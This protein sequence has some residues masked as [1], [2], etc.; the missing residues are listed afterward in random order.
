MTENPNRHPK[1]T[2]VGGQFAA[3]AHAE[4]DLTLPTGEPPVSLD[5]ALGDTTMLV[6]EEHEFGMNV[7]F[8]RATV[9][10]G[11]EGFHAAATIRENFVDGVA[12]VIA[13]Q[14]GYDLSDPEQATVADNESAAWLHER[15]DNIARYLDAAYGAELNPGSHWGEQ[16]V[17]FYTKMDADAQTD[18][19][20]DALTGGTNAPQVWHDL[21]EPDT[22]DEAFFDKI[23]ANCD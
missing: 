6:V 15:R 1:G 4:A 14:N 17:D 8:H 23:V 11:T 7:P 3:S 5:A 18:E 2:P 20:A 10:R 13:R 9:I 16:S 19:I 12:G 22:D 21:Y